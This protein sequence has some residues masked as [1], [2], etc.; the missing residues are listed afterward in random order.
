MKRCLPGTFCVMQQQPCHSYPCPP[1]MPT[2][3][4]Y[5]QRSF[6]A[7]P[8]YTQPG[9]Y[10][11]TGY[12]QPGGYPPQPG[13]NQPGGYPSQPGYNQPGYPPIGFNQPGYTQPGY[14]NQPQPGF[15]P[16]KF[17]SKDTV[18]HIIRNLFSLNGKLLNSCLKMCIF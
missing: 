17:F 16:G 7:E 10:P 3:R 4:N 13:F 9:Q 1:A 15:T 18:I 14:P 5:T 8:G 2:C 11:Q 6:H 12:N